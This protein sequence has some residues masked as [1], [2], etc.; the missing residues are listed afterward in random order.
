MKMHH[1]SCIIQQIWKD[2]HVRE[3]GI[4][5]KLHVRQ[6]IS[7]S[8]EE[9]AFIARDISRFAATSSAGWPRIF[10]SASCVLQ[11]RCCFADHVLIAGGEGCLIRHSLL[12]QA[13]VVLRLHDADVLSL[14]I[15]IS[16]EASVCKALRGHS[17]GSLP[18]GKEDFFIASF[19]S[20][21]VADF[22]EPSSI[23][24]EHISNAVPASWIG[25]MMIVS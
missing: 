19:M 8:S 7:M 25:T 3:S 18:K 5:H 4:C 13:E 11:S 15:Q 6:Y 21:F 12:S 20:L 9:H 10:S 24:C 23:P 2:S 22:R 1:A 16:I 14:L 17:T